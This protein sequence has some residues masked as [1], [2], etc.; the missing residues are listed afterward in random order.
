MHDP[1]LESLVDALIEAAFERGHMLERA[2]GDEM[3]ECERAEAD[4]R[5]A[6]LDY[7]DTEYGRD[8]LD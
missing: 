1:K 7:I 3:K 8:G 6:L 4:A 2:I 5:Q